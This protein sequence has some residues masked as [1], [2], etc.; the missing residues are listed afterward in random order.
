M[1]PDSREVSP[2]IRLAGA[3]TALMALYIYADFLSLHRPGQLEE[4]GRGTMGPFEVSQATLV[5]AS[6]IVIIP[7]L[8]IMG[9]LVLRLAINLW[10]NVVLA[11]V[12]A[13]INIGNLIGEGWAYYVL[14]G[15]VE[16]AVTGFIFVTA[17]RWRGESRGTGEPH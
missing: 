10:A 13:L 17:W 16:I 9:S 2:R 5:I 3:W 4:I 14:F 8:M 1:K 15:I 7:A 11:V 6:L 12:Y